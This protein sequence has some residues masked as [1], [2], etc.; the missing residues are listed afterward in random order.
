MSVSYS[1]PVKDLPGD[2]QVTVG[3]YSPIY[4][5]GREVCVYV[6]VY[7]GVGL[8]APCVCIWAHVGGCVSQASHSR[9]QRLPST[10]MAERYASMSMSVFMY[11]CICKCI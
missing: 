11:T 9:G 4:M 1:G 6:F 5:N 2:K 8:S 10:W 7:M 3:A